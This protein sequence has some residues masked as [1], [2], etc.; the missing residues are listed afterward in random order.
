MVKTLLPLL[1]S[2]SVA[3]CAAA[4]SSTPGTNWDHLKALPTGTRMHVTGDK[5]SRTCVLDAVTDEQLTCSKGRVV[6]TAHYTF[7][8]AEVQSVKLTRYTLS[9]VAGFGIGAG[10]GAGIAAATVKSGNIIGKGAAA[11]IFGIGGGVLGA[12]ITGLTDAFRGPTVYRKT[13]P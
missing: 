7:T 8:R 10:A 12:L 6:N 2:S 1:L 13:T 11:A 3:V 9:S 5:L 4:Q